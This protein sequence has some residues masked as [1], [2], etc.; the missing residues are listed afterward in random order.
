RC[1]VA[2]VGTL[3]DVLAAGVLAAS[4]VARGVVVRRPV[5]MPRSAVVLRGVFGGTIARP[6]RQVVE[7]PHQAARGEKPPEPQREKRRTR[8]AE[9]ALQNAPPR[10]RPAL[11][12]SIA[13]L[14]VTAL[15]PGAVKSSVT[16]PPRRTAPPAKAMVETSA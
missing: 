12:P 13:A 8:A 1:A 10:R 3:R 14:T 6:R 15:R 11:R 16:A 9:S 5:V 7:A 4:V 2:S